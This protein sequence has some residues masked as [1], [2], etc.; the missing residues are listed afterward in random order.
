MAAIASIAN[1]MAPREA[2]PTALPTW[3]ETPTATRIMGALSYAQALPDIAVVCGGS[4]IGKTYAARQY[5]STGAHVWI[6]TMTPATSGVVPALEEVCAAIGIPAANGAAPLHRAIVQRITG[7]AGLLIVDEAQHL[8][9]AALD[10]LRGIHDAGGIGL[11]LLGSRDLHTRMAGGE[12][13]T[14]LERLRGRIGRR[15]ALGTS[16]ASDAEAL[17]E[18][19]GVPAGGARKLLGEVATK[20]GGLRSVVKLLRVAMIHSPGAA[21][22]TESNL[23][24]AWRDLAG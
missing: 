17:A 20:A 21:P 2:T 9:P 24:A 16:T 12:A 19:C 14:T 5:A 1:P 3:V 8:I 11:V 15:L 22:F 13:A 23:R 18:A 7:A 6:A 4:G 10:Q